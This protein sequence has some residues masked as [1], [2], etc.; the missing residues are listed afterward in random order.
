MIIIR[1]YT[2]TSNTDAAASVGLN[3]TLL[4][5]TLIQVNHILLDMILQQKLINS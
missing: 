1:G 2:F 3:R 5:V 4:H